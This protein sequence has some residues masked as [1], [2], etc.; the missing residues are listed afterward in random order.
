M[1]GNLNIEERWYLA[2]EK[3]NIQRVKA[4][5]EEVDDINF[6]YLDTNPLFHII[7]NYGHEEKDTSK[8][9]GIIRWLIAEGAD[10]NKAVT[11]LNLTSYPIIEAYHTEKKVVE[12]L[13]EAGA[14]IN[15]ATHSSIFKEKFLSGRTIIKE[16]R[17]SYDWSDDPIF[18]YLKESG[19]L[20]FSECSLCGEPVMEKHDS[21]Y[22]YYGD[23]N[24]MESNGTTT[25]IEKFGIFKK[26]NK[27]EICESCIEKKKKQNFSN[28]VKLW[29]GFFVYGA[30]SFYLLLS[31]MLPDPDG[32][33]VTS[34]VGLTV[35]IYM[36][37][38][39]KKQGD[40][41][42]RFEV[43]GDKMAKKVTKKAMKNNG[44]FFTRE[45]SSVLNQDQL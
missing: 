30:G 20:L 26:P 9:W 34:I 45:E 38:L 24:K 32:V 23:L 36:F 31:G 42:S 1:S 14:D 15:L 29:I 28:L 3:R 39:I 12:L 44:S 21:Y 27:V 18:E 33:T 4:L 2:I 16:L 37:F 8:S 6:E 22:C 5:V 13:V 7:Q 19:K 10:V 17:R 43:V 41:D 11:T 25:T 35:I 40:H